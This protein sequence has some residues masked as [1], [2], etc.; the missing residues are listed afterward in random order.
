MSFLSRCII[1]IMAISIIGATPASA[2]DDFEAELAF[3]ASLGDNIVEAMVAEGISDK[4]RRNRLARI[5]IESVDIESLGRYIL[6]RYWRSADERQRTEYSRL[7][8]DYALDLYVSRFSKYADQ[9]L[10]VLMAR[11]AP[12]NTVLVS[13]EMVRREGPPAAVDFRLRTIDDR[14]RIIDVM[15]EGVSLVATK[16][17]EFAAIIGRDG[18][19]GLLAG[20]RK[21]SLRAD[22]KG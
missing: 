10:A 18:I 3:V 8:R 4:E 11:P 2:A 13:S 6:G 17:S 21:K 14:I 20:L 5:F 16:R 1:P 12:K 9:T 22:A 15:I 19:D 7:F